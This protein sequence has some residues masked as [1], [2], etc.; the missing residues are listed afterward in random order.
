I[1]ESGT[2]STSECSLQIFRY[3]VKGLFSSTDSA[4]TKVKGLLS[5]HIAFSNRR[6]E[7][8]PECSDARMIG[9]GGLA[10]CKM[11]EKEHMKWRSGETEIEAV[12]EVLFGC[13]FFDDNEEYKVC[14]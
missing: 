14:L 11:E 8:R 1:S 3:P 12:F 10:K 2:V 6:E 4:F 5:H 9:E 13:F 7:A